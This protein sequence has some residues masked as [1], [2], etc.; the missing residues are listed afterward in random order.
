V[1]ILD[2]LVL[3]LDGGFEPDEFSIVNINWE[4]VAMIWLS[5]DTLRWSL[6]MLKW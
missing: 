6:L 2:L 4:I 3:E 1:E 5:M